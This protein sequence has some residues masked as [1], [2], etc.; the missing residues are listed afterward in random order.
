ML[1]LSRKRLESIQIGD[2]V[3]VTVLSIRGKK[4]RLG[5]DAPA[6]IPVHRTELIDAIAAPSGS[7]VPI[8]HCPN[9][10]LT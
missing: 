4:V 10:L 2:D 9:D 3:V 8:T 7:P 5:I 6:Q 1:V